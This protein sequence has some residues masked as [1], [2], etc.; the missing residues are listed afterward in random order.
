[1]QDEGGDEDEGGYEGKG[2]EEDGGGV[3]WPLRGA[4]ITVV[5]IGKH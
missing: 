2:G 5:A 4:L 3:E 1:M